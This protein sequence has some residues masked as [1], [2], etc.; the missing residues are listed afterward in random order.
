M[1]SPIPLNMICQQARITVKPASGRGSMCRTCQPDCR[2]IDA[3][4]AD[5]QDA[6]EQ[7]TIGQGIV[8]SAAGAIVSDIAYLSSSLR[9]INRSII[10]PAEQSAPRTVHPPK[11]RRLRQ[12]GCKSHQIATPR[13]S[14]GWNNREYAIFISYNGV[15]PHEQREN[16]GGVAMLPHFAMRSVRATGLLSAV[17]VRPA[18]LKL[19]GEF[20]F[21]ETAG[22]RRR[23]I[24]AVIARPCH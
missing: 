23:T 10:A 2:S 8:S 18:A 1:I 21:P 14:E 12:A 17:Y 4:A 16:A 20:S 3:R 15:S 19:G 7:A 6:R 5:L 24:C 9:T 13:F 11:R 22:P